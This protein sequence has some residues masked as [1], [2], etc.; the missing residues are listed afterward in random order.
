M[1][2]SVTFH[3]AKCDQAITLALSETRDAPKNEPNEDRVEPGLWMAENDTYVVNIQDLDRVHVDA[4]PADVGCCGTF[5][6]TKPNLFC[7][8]DHPIGWQVDD[9]WT[10]RYARLIGDAVRP[11]TDDR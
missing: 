8:N 7:A 4:D 11:V 2:G 5:E 9:C 3:C 10:P 6:T 1:S